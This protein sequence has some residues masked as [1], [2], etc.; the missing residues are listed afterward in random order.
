MQDR[1][2]LGRALEMVRDL[3]QRCPWDRVQTR[4]TIRPYLVEEVFERRASPRDGGRSA[5]PPHHAEAALSD[6]VVGGVEATEEQAEGG[7]ER[8]LAKCS[9]FG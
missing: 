7:A 5:E 8:Y 1:S 6:R 4:E 3:R 9:R 2:A